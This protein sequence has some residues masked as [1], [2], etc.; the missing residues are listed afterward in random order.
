MTDAF[1]A[2]CVTRGLTH[3]RPRLLFRLREGLAEG[4]LARA[5]VEVATAQLPRPLVARHWILSPTARVR[6]LTR[7]HGGGDPLVVEWLRLETP[8]VVPTA[9]RPEPG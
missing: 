8:V 6:H 4:L 7:L 1:T 2:A 3:P 5:I 9:R